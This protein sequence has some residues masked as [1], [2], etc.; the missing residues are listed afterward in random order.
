MGGPQGSRG[1]Q[2]RPVPCQRRQRQ[3]LLRARRLPQLDLM[4]GLPSLAW[5]SKAAGLGKLAKALKQWNKRARARQDWLTMW[6][7]TGSGLGKSAAGFALAQ[8]LAKERRKPA[9]PISHALA[10]ARWA[11]PGA[12]AP[13]IMAMSHLND[14]APRVSQG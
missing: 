3:P 10:G 2:C 1:A 7:E 13:C 14:S 12:A 9:D 4:V 8:S 11:H 5:Q 6:Q